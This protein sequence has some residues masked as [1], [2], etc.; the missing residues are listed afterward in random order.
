[1]SVSFLFVCVWGW[2]GVVGWWW[3]VVGW[4][5]WWWWWLGG[6]GGG[7]EATVTNTMHVTKCQI[8]A[9]SFTKLIAY[10]ASKNDRPISLLLSVG[11]QVICQYIEV[12]YFSSSPLLKMAAISQTTFSNAFSWMGMYEFRLRFH[13]NLFSGSNQQYPSIGSDNGLALTRWQAII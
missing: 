10:V 3:W 1:M 11:F 12:G 7:N 2:V 4:W 6:G 5:W 8:F 13:W 9:C